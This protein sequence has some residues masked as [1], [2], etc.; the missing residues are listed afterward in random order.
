MYL[1]RRI[2]VPELFQGAYKN[3]DYFEGWYY[4][5]I[6]QDQQHIYAVIPGIALGQ[7]SADAHA[8][9][10]VINGQDGSVIYFKYPLTS[11]HYDKRKFSISIAENHFTRDFISL[12]LA[13]AGRSIDGQLCFSEIIPFPRTIFSP[14][15]MGPYSFVP[16]MECYHGII[17]ISHKIG[18]Q[19]HIDG[20]GVDFNGGEG[21]LEKDYGRSFPAE[22][23]WVQANHF[24]DH[25]TCFM[26]SLARIPWFRSSF[27]GMMCFLLYE[28]KLYRFATYNQAQ[29]TSMALNGKNLTASLQRKDQVLNFKVQA[30]PG[31][32]LKAPKNGLMSREIEETITAVVEVTLADRRGQIFSGQSLH[33]GY[34]ISSGAR[35]L[36]EISSSPSVNSH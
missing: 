22:W 27:I 18:G 28:G 23:I 17:N 26:F 8:F 32:F 1:L 31:G 35:E 21:Y 24:D 30:Q 11:F 14:G 10:Q 13:D 5:L 3:R 7:S 9:V 2:F 15:I 4:K 33:A 12:R 16:F 25:R 20:K 29:I 36:L 6:S 19:L 34:E